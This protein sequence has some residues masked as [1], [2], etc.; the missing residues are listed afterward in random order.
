MKSDIMGLERRGGRCE[1]KSGVEKYAAD[2]EIILPLLEGISFWS[3]P[4]GSLPPCWGRIKKIG[5]CHL[6]E[7]PKRAFDGQK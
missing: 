3:F 6:V 2:A 7:E 1:N 5:F 4:N